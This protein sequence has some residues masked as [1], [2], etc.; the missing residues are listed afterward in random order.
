MRGTLQTLNCLML[1]IGDHPRV[2]GE[3]V[4]A[5]VNHYLNQGSSPRM[6]GT[7]LVMSN[8]RKHD[9]IIPAYAGN[10]CLARLCCHGNGDHPRVCGEHVSAREHRKSVR[11]SSPRMRG[12]RRLRHRAG[13]PRGIIPAYA[14]NTRLTFSRLCAIRD[15][16]R[17]C[18]EHYQPFLFLCA[19][20]G[21]SPRMRGT[22]HCHVV[23]FIASGII[24]AYAGNT[25]SGLLSWLFFWDHPRVCGEHP[26]FAITRDDNK[27]SSP[28]MRGTL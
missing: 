5:E 2:C 15:H 19:G 9:G 20:G 18:G 3:H 25:S 13:S 14:G 8:Q 4:T 24:P 6:R 7:L 22:R 17:V 16:P 28:R 10:T 1:S 26:Y 12:T 27:G 23:S 11:G 21:S